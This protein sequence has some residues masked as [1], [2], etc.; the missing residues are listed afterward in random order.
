LAYRAA[1]IFRLVKGDFATARSRI[2]HGLAVDR[3]GNVALMLPLD[4][5]LLGRV[6]AELGKATEAANLLHEA[7]KYHEHLLASDYPYRGTSVY[8]KLGRSSLLLGRLDEA[9]SLTDRAVELSGRHPGFAARALHL[10][11]DIAIHPDRFDG[12]S[13]K[14][15]Y[16]K[17][18]ALAESREMRPL[19]AQ[20]HLGLGKVNR[21][22]SRQ[23]QALKHLTVAI[24]MYRE[25]G[26]TYWWKQVE[27]EL[28]QL[29]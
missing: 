27:A 1:G 9:R 24:T 19:I 18:L 26:L 12:K 4:V 14:V 11:G 22:S 21:L 23:D 15:Y 25:M 8:F 7:E 17:A 3:T 20:C 13:A 16:Q 29:G 6:L 28:H 2:E 10:L 5:A